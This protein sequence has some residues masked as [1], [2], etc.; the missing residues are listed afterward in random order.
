M[1]SNCRR[2]RSQSWDSQPMWSKSGGAG[3]AEPPVPLPRG[4]DPSCQLPGRSELSGQRA[5]CCVIYSVNIFT[6]ISDSELHRGK[7][8]LEA[9]SPQ[10]PA[11]TSPLRMERLKITSAGRHACCPHLAD[12]NTAFCWEIGTDIYTLLCIK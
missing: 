11:P 3:L 10:N 8:L 2:H 9:E 1:A 7:A 5:A 12:E 6:S 4:P